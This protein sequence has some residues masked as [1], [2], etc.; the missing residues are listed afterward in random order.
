MYL[1]PIY[2]KLRVTT[3][4]TSLLLRSFA[5]L[6]L[7]LALRGSGQVFFWLG[8]ATFLVFPLVL[9]STVWCVLRPACPPAC[10]CGCQTVRVIGLCT[11]LRGSDCEMSP[12]NMLMSQGPHGAIRRR[13]LTLLDRCVC[14]C[15]C[16]GNTDTIHSCGPYTR[17]QEFIGM[18]ECV[19]QTHIHMYVHGHIVHDAHHPST[20]VSPPPRLALGVRGLRRWDDGLN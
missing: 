5:Q 20:S 13:N 6:R 17:T 3:H 10:L 16:V 4:L 11:L 9:H 14:V 7:V 2:C 19:I 1:A 12:F 8:P 18:C 15:V